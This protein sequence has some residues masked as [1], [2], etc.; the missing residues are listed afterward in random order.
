MFP[1]DRVP[2]EL[3]SKW[4]PDH[5]ESTSTAGGCWLTVT[6]CWLTGCWLTLT[7]QE[8]ETELRQPPLGLHFYVFFFAKDC[9]L[10]FFKSCVSS[11]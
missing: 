10:S 7:E 8:E 2:P 3:K 1:L 5:L 4:K 11:L 6:R 9:F